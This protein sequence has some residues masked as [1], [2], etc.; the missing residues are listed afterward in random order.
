[1]LLKQKQIEKLK[2]LLCFLYNKNPYYS[3][4]LKNMNCDPNCDDI[5]LI[6]NQ[7]PYITKDDIINNYDSLLTPSILE[8]NNENFD[9]TSGSS[10]NVLKC[11][12][13]YE[14]R[15]KLAINIWKKRRNIDP[16]VTPENYVNIFSKDFEKVIGKFYNTSEDMLCKNLKRIMDLKPRWISGPVSIFERFAIL[17]NEGFPYKRQ[18]LKYIEFMGEYVDPKQRALIEKAFDCSTVNNY[19]AQELWCIAFDCKNKQLHIQEDFCIVDYLDKKSINKYGE[20]IITSLNNYLMPLIKYKIGDI[21][22]ITDEP[23]TCLTNSSRILL[24]GGRT[25]DIIYGSNILGNYFFDQIIW[26]I[27]NKYGNAIFAFKVIQLEKYVFNFFI[28]KGHSYN[29]DVLSTISAR[30][31]YE[32]GMNTKINYIFKDN[33]EF[34]PTG[35]LKK[36][37]PF[38]SN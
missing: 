14:E 28:V 21:A 34:G 12:K 9:I 1:M 16:G 27:N 37:T 22:L 36:F 18:D 3:S 31:K 33:L 38:I 10:G 29:D 8:R 35:K 5:Q 20:I 17:I 15:S 26:D 25:G 32:I 23:C 6:Y 30:M 24:A 19:G 11:Y 13:S 2:K 4:I 7:M